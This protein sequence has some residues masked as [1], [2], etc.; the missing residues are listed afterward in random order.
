[1]SMDKPR[2]QEAESQF[3]ILFEKSPDAFMLL[4]DGIFT[5]CNEATLGQFGMRREEL[6]GR[7][8]H[9]LSPPFQ[10]GGVPSRDAAL[11]HIRDAL[12]RG[13]GKFE[14]VHRRADGSEFWADITLTSLVSGSE[15]VL[16]AAVRDITERK[17]AEEALRGSE[18]RCRKLI[19]ASPQGIIIVKA[20]SRTSLFANPEFCRLFGYEAG[21][22]HGLRIDDLHPADALPAVHQH[23]AEMLAGREKLAPELLCRRADGSTFYADIAVALV[24]L[25]G[26]ACVAGMFADVTER[27]L[28]EERRREI[29]RRLLHAQKLESMGVL[30]GGIAHDFNNLLTAILGNLD[31]SLEELPPDSPAR[32]S[33]SNAIR[34]A[35]SAADLTRQMLAYSGKGRFVVKPVDFNEVV[36]ANADL[37]RSSAARSAALVVNLGAALPR[38]EADPAQIQ[39]VVMNLVT[40]ASEA[41][42]DRAGTI[43]LTTGTAEYDDEALG[44]SQLAEKP[45]PGMYV[46]IEVTD[47][48][49]GMDGAALRRLFEPFYTTKCT[50][51]GLG[52]SV[53]L[54]IVRGHKG[55]IFVQ[56]EVGRGTSIR[57]A[58][59]AG[60]PAEAGEETGAGAPSARSGRRNG[61][62]LFVDD[63]ATIRSLCEAFAERF[64]FRAFVAADGRAGLE[65][66]AA[67]ADEIDCVILDLTMPRM[68]GLNAFREMKRIRSGVRV[69]LMS[70]YNEQ[71]AT[72]LFGGEGLA[73]FLEK[74]FRIQALEETL[75][76]ILGG[77]A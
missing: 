8:P 27:R 33:I 43:S 62:L 24:E 2:P 32:G 30:A 63:E 48:G 51:R 44:R 23:F 29:E 1:M 45:E 37:V 76:A 50:G 52:M 26:E 75:N 11:A 64:G 40:N 41:I 4:A 36:R 58:F 65:L 21:A 53:V 55:A 46:F 54:G 7:S 25:E 17:R 31:L 56:S 57:V 16:C 61:T 69:V 67:H 6:V 47:D 42:G 60:R 66:F 71:H 14:W 39:Q 18:E 68:D 22:L 15:K 73:G 77:G 9:D 13:A 12:G 49:S 38:V 19:D 34:A 35:N 10:P 72:R 5:D 3:R 20:S 28:A 70:G 74:P 59:P